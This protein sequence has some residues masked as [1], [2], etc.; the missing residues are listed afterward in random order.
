[1]KFGTREKTID[2]F[3][4]ARQVSDPEE[5][6]NRPDECD[7]ERQGMVQ[8]FRIL[9][10]QQRALH[11]PIRITLQPERPCQNCAGQ[12]SAVEAEIVRRGPVGTRPASQRRFQRGLGAAQL[13]A[14]VKRNPHQGMRQC[15]GD[16]ILER[17]S[18]DGTAL[19]IAQRDPELSPAQVEHLQRA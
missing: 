4:C 7:G 13:S 2:V 16:R 6:R 12:N 5:H 9:D 14:E 17:C 3:L 1:M 18:D 11:G 8:D 19:R 10:R 15:G